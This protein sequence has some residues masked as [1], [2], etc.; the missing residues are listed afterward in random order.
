MQIYRRTPATL[1]TAEVHAL[2]VKSTVCLLH[3]DDISLPTFNLKPIVRR[4]RREPF[5]SLLLGIETNDH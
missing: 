3:F 1:G 2:P 5:K 4:I